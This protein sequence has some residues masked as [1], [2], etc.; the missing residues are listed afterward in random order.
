MYGA[1]SWASDPE[2]DGR[3][4]HFTSARRV[5]IEDA[6]HNLHHHR[7]EE[8]LAHLQAFLHGSD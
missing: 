8:F 7:P 6:G 3:M 5:L 2:Q 1:R 4:V